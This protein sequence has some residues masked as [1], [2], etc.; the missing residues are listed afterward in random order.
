MWPPTSAAAL[1]PDFAPELCMRTTGRPASRPPICIIAPPRVGPPPAHGTVMTVHNLAFPG[2]VAGDAAGNARPAARR[3]RDR[4]RRVPRHHR[5]P[6]GRPAIRRP[7]HHRLADLRG[8]NPHAGGGHGSRRPAARA[9]R[10]AVGHPERHR[11]E[12]L[13]PRP[14]SASPPATTGPRCG[15]APRTRPRCRRASGSPAIPPRRC[16]A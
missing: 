2:Q 8:R 3:L 10:C 11:H 4:R 5:L 12:G 16:S 9:R 6:E 1:L 15:G 14:T 13:E 7:D